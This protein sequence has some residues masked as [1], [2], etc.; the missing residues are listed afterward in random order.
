M[1]NLYDKEAFAWKSN[2]LSDA[3]SFWK[4]KSRKFINKH[5]VEWV[6]NFCDKVMV[7]AKSGFTKATKALIKFKFDNRFPH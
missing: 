3:S 4:S 7:R 6:P 1:R 5:L 2:N